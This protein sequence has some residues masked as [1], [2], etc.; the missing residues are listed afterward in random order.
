MKISTNRILTTHTGSL[1]R[2]ADVVE[3][4]K[5]NEVGQIKDPA[6]MAGVSVPADDADTAAE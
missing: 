1:P 3:L 2:P 6:Q 4:I 5:Q